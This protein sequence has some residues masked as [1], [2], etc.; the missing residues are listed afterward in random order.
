MRSEKCSPH[1]IKIG[2]AM[3]SRLTI[4]NW[5]LEVRSWKLEIRKYTP[6]ILTSILY[7]LTS[8][9]LE[10]QVLK[11]YQQIAQENNPS[12][13]AQYKQFEADMTRVQQVNG[14]PDPTLSFGY[15]VSPVETRVGPQ[16]ARFSLTQ[17]FPWFGTLKAKGDVATL[18]AEASYQRFVDEQNKIRF[19]V[20]AAYFP[21][22]ELEQIQ[23]IQQENLQLLD[24]WKR[25]AT[26]KYENGQTSLADVLRIDLRKKEIETELS[27]I[28]DEKRPLLVAFNNLLNRTDT[29]TVTL[30]DSA[31]L[32]FN[33]LE[34]PDWT[35][36]PQLKEMAKRI[37]ASQNQLIVI[38]KSGLPRLGAGVDYMIIGERT[39]VNVADNGKNAL[40][41]MV[42]L[43]LPIFRG[44]YKEAQRETE[45]KIEG[46]QYFIENKENTLTTQ[47]EKLKFEANRELRLQELYRV[48]LLET[49]QIQNL[50]FTAFSD[51]GEDLDEL[52]RIQM[53]LLGYSLKQEKSKT[54][55]KTKV[56]EL[57]YLMS[58]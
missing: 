35:D 55:L 56:A 51:S 17:M 26:I 20:A 8:V 31:Y 38:E 28:E 43:S 41:P 29:A 30:T 18:Q 36:N 11:D 24:S 45:L 16:Q 53:E 39:D 44:K 40:M 23:E 47:Y 33:R 50:L 4:R 3:G 52:L 25:L 42:T 2:K 54:R 34:E 1:F 13:K 58:R 19:Q 7:L 32:D 5:K 27:L 49:Q 12:V 48:Q 57:D 15:F 6:I 22:V 46:L 21:L 10:A 9:E 14:L 37:E